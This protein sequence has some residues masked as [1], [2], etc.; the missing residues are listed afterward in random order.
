[1]TKP[2]AAAASITGW[3]MPLVML[4]GLFGGPEN[5][6]KII[7]HLP[8]D[9]LPLAEL[10]RFFDKHRNL[11][12]L[13][14]LTD[15]VQQNINDLA[16]HRVVL[17]GNSLG[18]HIAVWLTLRMPERVCGL[19]LTGSSGLFE[20]G[21]TRVPGKRPPRHWVRKKACEVFYDPSYV[22]D[23]L[24]DSVMGVIYDRNRLRILLSLAKSAKRDN[25]GDKLKL[26][27]CPTL[28]IWGRQD[29][30]TPP[31]VA[32]SFHKC[33]PTSKLV[34]I[35]GCGHAQMIERPL[36][37]ANHLDNWWMTQVRSCV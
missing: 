13:P 6:K 32:H 15:A 22:T 7:P 19:V 16:Y 26:I 24:V 29:K 2:E 25:V 5:W 37:F 14:G 21:F 17:M 34:W 1:M 36:E 11:H 10:L 23:T 4:H 35:D 33:I 12:T 27:R 31:E 9:C 20:R 28:L 30:I 3:R 8:K 18:G